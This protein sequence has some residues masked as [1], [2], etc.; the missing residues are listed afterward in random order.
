MDAAS[1]STVPV[2]AT[3]HDRVVSFRV[4]SSLIAKAEKV[5]ADRGMGLSELMRAALRRELRRAA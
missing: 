3:G 1:N 2:K 5:A 4:R